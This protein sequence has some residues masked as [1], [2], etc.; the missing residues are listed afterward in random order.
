[1]GSRHWDLW[2]YGKWRRRNI[3]VGEDI[4]I[5]HKDNIVNMEI[6]E[7]DEA[8]DDINREEHIEYYEQWMIDAYVTE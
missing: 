3:M 2:K 4:P 7:G 8:N 5:Q 6:E 1:M